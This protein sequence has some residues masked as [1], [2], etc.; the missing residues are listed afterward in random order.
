MCTY[1]NSVSATIAHYQYLGGIK[2]NQQKDA[3]TCQYSLKRELKGEKHGTS[4][5]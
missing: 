1:V 5:R 3:E 2:I 4:C